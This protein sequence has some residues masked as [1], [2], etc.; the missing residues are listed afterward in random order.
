MVEGVGLGGYRYD[1][2]RTNGNKDGQ[3][4]GRR[5]EAHRA[6]PGGLKKDKAWDAEL[7]LGRRVAEAQ[8]WARDLVNEPAAR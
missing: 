6:A 2:W 1:K 3:G 4:P 8:N 5:R 7:E